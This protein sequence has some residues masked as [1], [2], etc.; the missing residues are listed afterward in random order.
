MDALVGFVLVVLVGILIIFQVV[1]VAKYA[2]RQIDQEHDRKN[3][4]K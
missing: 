1:R 3:S 2:S 4:G